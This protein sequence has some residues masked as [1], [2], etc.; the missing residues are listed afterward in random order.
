[1]E[2]ENN[3]LGRSGGLVSPVPSVL[4]LTSDLGFSFPRQSDRKKRRDRRKGSLPQ[5]GNK[6]KEEKEKDDKSGAGAGGDTEE[7]ER[8]RFT[9]EEGGEPNRRDK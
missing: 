2:R 1:M 3:L 4:G 8:I 7:L 6:E 5:A 9:G